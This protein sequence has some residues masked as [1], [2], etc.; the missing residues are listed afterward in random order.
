MQT[1]HAGE[2]DCS[3]YCLKNDEDHNHYDNDYDYDV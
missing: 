3:D 2:E 1:V